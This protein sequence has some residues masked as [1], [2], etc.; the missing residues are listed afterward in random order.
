MKRLTLLLA[1]LPAL[2]FANIDRGLVTTPKISK[3][4]PARYFVVES[5]Q[6]TTIAGA[7]VW[8]WVYPFATPARLVDLIVYQVGAGTV[9]TSWTATLRDATP[10]SLMTTSG[11]ATQASGA[12]LVTDAKG[13]LSLPAGW[14]RPVL[15]TDATT[16]YSKGE[17]IEIYTAETGAYTVHPTGIVA[18][19]F[20][21]LY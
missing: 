1:L 18:L 13:E 14:T 8:R 4:T 11:L 20:E 12:N 5:N 3:A 10:T 6:F 17:Y 2:A 19:V 9:G 15:K 21:P 7:A 16:L